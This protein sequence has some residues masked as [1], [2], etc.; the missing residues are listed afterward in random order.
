MRRVWADASGRG[1]GRNPGCVWAGRR[2]FVAGAG[3][4]L[5][6]VHAAARVPACAGAARSCAPR[7]SV[8]RAPAFFVYC[9]CAHFVYIARTFFLYIACAFFVYC[10]RILVYC[11]RTF[12]YCACICMLRA[13]IM[14][15]L[16]I[17]RP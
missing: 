12:V 4:G 11:A 17:L 15:F 10:A 14:Y 8:L 16:C 7:T 13:Y 1:C 5:M 6:P 9:A 3:S 2:M